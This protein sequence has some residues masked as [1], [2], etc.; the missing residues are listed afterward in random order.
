M[1]DQA[2]NDALF[3]EI[4]ANAQRAKS[5]S[6]DG[7]AVTQ[8]DPLV[9]VAVAKFFGAQLAAGNGRLGMAS[10]RTKFPGASGVQR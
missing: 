9:Q 10:R 6:V 4:A 2:A 7:E 8:Q 5:V 3:T 1:I